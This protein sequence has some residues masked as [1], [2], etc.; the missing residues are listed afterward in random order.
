M[1]SFR[2]RVIQKP[3]FSE[4]VGFWY[5]FYPLSTASLICNK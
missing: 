5:D 2:E 3:T 1:I 4:K